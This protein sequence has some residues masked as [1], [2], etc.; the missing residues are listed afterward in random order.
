[1]TH[2]EKQLSNHPTR[3]ALLSTLDGGGFSWELRVHVRDCNR[4]A[5]RLDLLDKM[6]SALRELPHPAWL[7]RGLR[8]TPELRERILERLRSETRR[9][10]AR[11]LREFVAQSLVLL[12]HPASRVSMRLGTEAN[13][14]ARPVRPQVAP[15][16]GGATRT[17][18]AQGSGPDEAAHFGRDLARFQPRHAHEDPA[19][20]AR[21][22]LVDV[23]V[24]IGRM[25]QR[26]RRTRHAAD[27][28]PLDALPLRL[29][30]ALT[31]EAAVQRVLAVAPDFQI[32]V[33]FVR[34]AKDLLAQQ[35]ASAL[36][37]A[38]LGLA[39]TR[40]SGRSD[41]QNPTAAPSLRDSLAPR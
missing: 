32:S 40:S 16:A 7:E 20:V 6:G 36:A 41:P 27:G 3:C 24:D 38:A 1:M 23:L 26:A 35:P 18:P 31:A 9:H 5:Q 21:R 4:C 13:R 22:A 17:T 10:L 11:W 28:L 8:S 29:P 30:T 33:Q 34:R 37:V 19:A 39:A 2:C 25:A 15:A 14:S 12:G